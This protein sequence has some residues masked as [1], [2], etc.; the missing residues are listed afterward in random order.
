MSVPDVL[1]MPLLP[2]TEVPG[3]GKV[4]A[5]GWIGERYYWLLGERGGISMMPASVVEKAKGER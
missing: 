3:F 4:I 1:T 5:V 2:G